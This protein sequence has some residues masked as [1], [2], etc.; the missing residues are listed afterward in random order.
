[1]KGVDEAK[2]ELEEIVEYLKDPHKFTAL[3]GKLPKVWNVLECI[4]NARC[5]KT[6]C[7]CNMQCHSVAALQPGLWLTKWCTLTAVLGVLTVGC[8]M[9]RCLQNTTGF[10]LLPQRQSTDHAALANTLLAT[11]IPSW[12]FGSCLVYC[13][14]AVPALANATSK[15]VVLAGFLK[16]DAA[17]YA[18]GGV[19]LQI[20]VHQVAC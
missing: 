14:L 8:L 2:A 13:L 16:R 15:A 7:T 3:G 5:R 11:F 19:L 9:V 20:I 6:M 1:M 12:L 18:C 10:H 4:K 17:S